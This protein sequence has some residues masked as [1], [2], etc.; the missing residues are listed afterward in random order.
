MLKFVKKI[1]YLF[2]SL[3]SLVAGF[4]LFLSPVSFNTGKLVKEI[5]WGEVYFPE[6][7]N[8]TYVPFIA[9][10]VLVIVGIVLL[11][12]FF[13]PRLSRFLEV[14]I[15]AISGVSIGLL[16]STSAFYANAQLISSS[17]VGDTIFYSNGLGVVCGIALAALS[18]ILVFFGSA[19]KR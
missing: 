9:F 14:P 5:A 1:C 15:V 12:L 2:A 11:F 10:I 6:D 18:L 19:I 3:A 4:M 7:G 17:L 16:A 8:G 13:F